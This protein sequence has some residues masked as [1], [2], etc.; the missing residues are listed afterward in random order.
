MTPEELAPRLWDAY[1]ASFLSTLAVGRAAALPTKWGE[2][3][4]VERASWLAAAREALA[5][6]PGDGGQEAP[7]RYVP[8]KFT[9]AYLADG[10]GGPKVIMEICPACTAQLPLALRDCFC[11]VQCTWAGC[12]WDD[13]ANL[14]A[15]ARKA[16]AA[17]EAAS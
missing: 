2:L 4:D 6:A 7:G 3:S 14:N 17:R 11:R 5:A 13:P 9:A 12:P 10:I 15:V 8:G 16:D 1:A